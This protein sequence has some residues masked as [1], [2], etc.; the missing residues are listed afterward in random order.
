[1]PKSLALAALL[2]VLAATPAL[3]ADQTP[4]SGTAIWSGPLP[5]LKPVRI[6]RKRK[7]QT[8]F[9]ARTRQRRGLADVLLGRR[10]DAGTIAVKRRHRLGNVRQ[11]HARGRA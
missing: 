6:A 5:F 1:M 10:R 11:A 8:D 3:R 7:M 2:A 9:D 4:V